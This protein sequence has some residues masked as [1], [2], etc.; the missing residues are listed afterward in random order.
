MDTSIV[1]SLLV[2]EEGRPFSERE[3][4]ASQLNL[5][6][7]DLFSLAQVSLD[8]AAFDKADSLVPVIV[9]VAEAKRRTV[10]RERGYASQDCFRVSAGLGDAQFPRVGAD[11]RHQRAGLEDRRG[12]D[13]PASSTGT[14]RT[15]SV[16]G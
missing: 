6:R 3:I 7:S 15:A 8:T 10:K 9:K 16:R 11:P 1:R 14:W 13:S 5:Y 4:T 12:V 2:V